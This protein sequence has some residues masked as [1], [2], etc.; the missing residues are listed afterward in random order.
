MLSFSFIVSLEKNHFFFMGSG[1]EYLWS[2]VNVIPASPRK[3]SVPKYFPIFRYSFT[4]FFP[5]I[6]GATLTTASYAILHIAIVIATFS[7]T[8]SVPMCSEIDTIFNIPPHRITIKKIVLFFYHS[9]NFTGSTV[10]QHKHTQKI[11]QNSY[12]NLN[13]QSHPYSLSKK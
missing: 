12:Y 10:F 9:D 2:A 6:H 4:F 7:L 13:K 11:H 8:T 3:P 1:P 5:T